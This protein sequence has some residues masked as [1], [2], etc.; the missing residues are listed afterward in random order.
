MV[1]QL[2]VYA[3]T[4]VK[5]FFFII[6]VYLP[7]GFSKVS[8]SCTTRKSKSRLFAGDKNRKHMMRTVEVYC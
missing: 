3:N 8:L 5:V 2:T 7:E 1:V 6:I 4:E